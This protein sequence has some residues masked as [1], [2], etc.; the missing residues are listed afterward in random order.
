MTIGCDSEDGDLPLCNQ[1]TLATLVGFHDGGGDGK[2]GIDE[3]E[4]LVWALGVTAS[5]FGL[6]DC[7]FECG[8]RTPTCGLK[9]GNSLMAPAPQ[10]GSF[11]VFDGSRAF[12]GF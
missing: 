1:L 10:S 9:P 12:G 2:C 7:G 5:K 8:L 3:L 6:H 11:S 4:A